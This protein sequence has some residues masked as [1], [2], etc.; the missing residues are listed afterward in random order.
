MPFDGALMRSAVATVTRGANNTR[1][2]TAALPL[3]S[4]VIRIHLRGQLG[5]GWRLKAIPPSLP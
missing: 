1:H 5:E 3:A 2:A 4:S